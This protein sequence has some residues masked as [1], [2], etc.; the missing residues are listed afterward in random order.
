MLLRRDLAAINQRHRTGYALQEI[1]LNTAA[2]GVPQMRERLFLVATVDGRGFRLPPATMAR[3]MGSTAI[4]R[5]DAI[6]RGS[7]KMASDPGRPPLAA[8]LPSIPEAE[9]P[10]A[11]AA[12]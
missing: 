6:G 8:L 9:L 11:H 4:V 10:M 12:K 2:Y 7:G 3:L 5:Q 1:H